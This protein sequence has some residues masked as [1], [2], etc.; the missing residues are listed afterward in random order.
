MTSDGAQELENDD[1]HYVST[2]WMPTS[3]SFSVP[4]DG[5]ILN[6]NVLALPLVSFRGQLFCL[7]DARAVMHFS[8]PR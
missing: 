3:S 1:L 2:D 7:F 8:V 6:P 5:G 4:M